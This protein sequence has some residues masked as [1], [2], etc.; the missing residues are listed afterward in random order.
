MKYMK[1]VVVTLVL[2]MTMSMLAACSSGREFSPKGNGMYVS[3]EGQFSTAFEEVI[4]KA[5]SQIDTKGSD[6]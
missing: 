4:D 3:K 6:A 1:L 5:F 2:C